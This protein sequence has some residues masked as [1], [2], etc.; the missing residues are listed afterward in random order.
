MLKALLHDS[1]TKM[2]SVCGNVWG[3][4]FSGHKY[5]ERHKI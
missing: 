1:I 3:L 5:L 2:A 4:Q